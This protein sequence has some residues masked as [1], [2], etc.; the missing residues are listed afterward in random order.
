MF[1]GN[2]RHT[3]V[4]ETQLDKNRLNLQMNYDCSPACS[5]WITNV[6]KNILDIKMIY[7]WLQAHVHISNLLGHLVVTFI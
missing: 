3:H 7:D 5:C 6:D 4:G 1:F 2:R